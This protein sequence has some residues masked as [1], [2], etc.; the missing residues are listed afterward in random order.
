MYV[1]VILENTGKWEN[2]YVRVLILTIIM[3]HQSA[4][5]AIIV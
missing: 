4:S 1:S 2:G 3:S 5:K